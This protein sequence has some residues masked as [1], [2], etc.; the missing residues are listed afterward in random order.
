MG[1]VGWM[2]ETERWSFVRYAQED[3]RPCFPFT[4]LTLL[5]IMSAIERAL[6]GELSQSGI[7]PKCEMEILVLPPEAVSVWL[8]QMTV[9]GGRR[10]D[11]ARA[12]TV[13]MKTR[14]KDTTRHTPIVICCGCLS[15]QNQKLQK[16]PGLSFKNLFQWELQ[17]AW[18]LA[19]GTQTNAAVVGH[20]NEKL[21]SSCWF[22][23]GEV[24]LLKTT[25]RSAGVVETAKKHSG[26]N[27][28]WLFLPLRWSL[29]EHNQ[30]QKHT[31][32]QH[33]C[34]LWLLMKK[35]FLKMRAHAS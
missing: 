8:W 1:E 28:E 19:P 30:W 7:P 31:K 20:H 34:I 6:W 23:L 24:V 2:L 25:Y 14:P 33:F 13:N 32:T 26:N 17:H 18:L 4:W 10:P 35:C 16:E 12:W 29:A 22:W 15:P 11:S 5:G 27:T 9:A 3:F 21:L